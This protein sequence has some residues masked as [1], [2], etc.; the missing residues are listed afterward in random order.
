MVGH[1][2]PLISGKEQWIG[3]DNIYALTN[4]HG[5]NMQLRITMEKFSKD[6]ATAYYDNFFLEDRVREV[7]KL[8]SYFTCEFKI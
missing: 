6:E 7:L 2:R 5:V 8:K 4:Q 3:L 1:N